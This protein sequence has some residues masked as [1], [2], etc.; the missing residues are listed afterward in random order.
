MYFKY[1][2]LW[3]AHLLYCGI[4]LL[5][6]PFEL[7]LG[8]YEHYDVSYLSENIHFDAKMTHIKMVAAALM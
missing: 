6:C 2:T 3:L 4:Q 1:L 8:W 5:F 7:L